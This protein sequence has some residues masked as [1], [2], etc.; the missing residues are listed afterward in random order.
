MTEETST[1]ADLAAE[2]RGKLVDELCEW[3]PFRTAAV[4]DAMRTVPRHVFLPGVPIEKAYSHD[5]I[6]THRDSE[7]VALSSASQPGVVGAMLEQLDTRPGHRV[8]EIGAGTGYNAALLAYLVGSAGEVTTVDIDAEVVEGTR[9]NLDAAGYAGVRVIYGDGDDGY[10]AAAPFDRIIVTAG[11]WDIPPAWLEQLAPGG[12]IVV[13]LRIR[14]LTRSVALERDG[15][16]W[17]SRSTEYCGFIPLR[18]AGHPPER[19]IQLDK[20]GKLILRIDEGRPVDGK[21]LRPSLEEAPVELWTGITVTDAEKKTGLG[22]LDYWLATRYDLCRLIT[23]SRNHGLVTPVY[24]W[25]SMAI[26]DQETL[27][28]L[29]KRPTGDVGESELGVCAYGPAG[30]ELASRAAERIRAWDTGRRLAT[31]IEVYPYGAPAPDLG[32]LLVADKRH[33]R[34]IVRAVPLADRTCSE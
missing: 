18:G 14:G 15:G 12:R 34:V 32:A 7:G 5:N 24:G 19:N 30:G 13:P 2:L 9:R 11:A 21:A 22:D 8:L 20:D 6:V 16:C 27:A 31:R 17:H 25:G 26:L 3:E 4:E 10:P 28:Y 33:I 29:I 23:R 1:V